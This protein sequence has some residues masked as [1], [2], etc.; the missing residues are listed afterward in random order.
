MSKHN[1]PEII[2]TKWEKKN[3]AEAEHVS[4]KVEQKYNKRNETIS[5]LTKF[6]SEWN[7][8]K[9]RNTDGEQFSSPMTTDKKKWH[10]SRTKILQ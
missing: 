10:W 3:D 2:M 6:T 5:N 1:I 7:N 8:D 4:F 9:R